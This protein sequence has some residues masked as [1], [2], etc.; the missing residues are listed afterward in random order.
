MTRPTWR[1]ALCPAC[2]AA[3]CLGSGTAPREPV[4]AVG[5]D[6]DP[7]CV[8]GEATTIYVRISPELT[9]GL[10]LAARES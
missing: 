5:V 10:A 7:C 2:F 9:A 8:C 3:F 4:R 1:Q 6:G